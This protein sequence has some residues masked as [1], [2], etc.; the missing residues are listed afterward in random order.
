MS[1]FYLH[2]QKGKNCYCIFH[3]KD[4]FPCHALCVCSVIQSCPTLCDPTNCSR[5]APL[6]M[7]FP[8]QEHW[9]GCRFLLQRIFLTPVSNSRLQWL[10]HWQVD[11]LP[12]R[13]LGSPHTSHLNSKV[14]TLW[15]KERVGCF[16]RTASK[17]VQY[18]GWNI[19]SPGWMHETSART[20]CTGK[21]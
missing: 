12:L 1:M 20:W 5:Q 16:K 13:Y 10:L 18:L 21:T 9:N 4:L 15:E 11:S 7:G 19:T 3:E 8:R 17:H 2:I 14:L 6:S